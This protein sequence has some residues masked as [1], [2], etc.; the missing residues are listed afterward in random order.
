[1]L[2]TGAGLAL[3]TGMWNSMIAYTKTRKWGFSSR[4]SDSSEYD[5]MEFGGKQM[6]ALRAYFI[7]GLTLNLSVPQSSQ[8]FLQN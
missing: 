2:F 4:M 5:M 6:L 3:E 8:D 7:R 1:M